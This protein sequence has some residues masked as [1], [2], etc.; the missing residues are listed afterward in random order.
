M[1]KITGIVLIAIFGAAGAFGQGSY[2]EQWKQVESL[3]RKG[4]PQSALS[5]VDAIYASARQA[6]DGPQFLKAVLYQIRLR[7]D[8][9]EDFIE[10]SLVQ[11]GRDISETTPPVSNILHSVRAELYW[12][13]YQGN[14]Y[15][16]M[17]RTR[18][19]TPDST[20][21]KT[22][23]LETLITQVASGY[24]T[25]L[26]DADILR[27]TL[28]EPFDPIIVKKEGSDRFRPT[29]YDFL[30][31][32]AADFFMTG[33]AGITRPAANF[34]ADKPDY[35]RNAAQFTLLG[36]PK[37][38]DDDF[39]L[40]ALLIL[41]DL[42]SFHLLDNDPAALVDADLKRLRFVRDI[43]TVNDRDELYLAALEELKAAYPGNPATADVAYETALEYYRRGQEYNPFLSDRYRWDLRKAKEICEATQAE[44]PGTDGSTNCAVLLRMITEPTLSVNFPDAVV[45]GRPALASLNFRN[46][47]QATFR[48]VK[49]DPK[50]VS[51][52][53]MQRQMD[54]LA[55][56]YAQMAPVKQWA[57][58][59]PDEGDFQ[60][61]TAEISILELDPGYYV[62][63]ASP[64]AII[65]PQ[66]APV[67]LA[68][69]WVTGIS[70][71]SSG[72][73][74]GVPAEILILDRQKGTPLK[75]VR[76]EAFTREYD[77]K[78]R[79]Y[80][81]NPQGSYV[82][83]AEGRVS[84]PALEREMKSFY[85][86]MSQGD[87]VY[88]T[89]NYFFVYPAPEPEKPRKTAHFFTD[90]SIYRPGQSV[91]F[92]AILLN[93]SD[94][95]T[96][97]VAD[98][99]FT[100]TLYDANHQKVTES[101][102]TTNEF[103]SVQGVFTLPQGGLTG[104]MSLE[105][106]WGSISF[107]VE[108]YKRPR[109]R[110]EIDSL[111]GNY[112]LGEI[113]NVT[114][115]ALNYTGV[116][117]DGATVSYR[118]VRGTRF[119]VWR[120][121]WTWFPA[122]P[123][124]EIANGTV[125]TEPDGS[126][127]F[128]FTA[129]PDRMVEEK[130]QP[131]F[132]Y[133]IYVDV[134]DITGE[135]RSAEG[136]V[137]VGYKALLMEVKV[138]VNLDIRGK[139]QF[140]LQ[141][142]NLNGRP[143]AAGGKLSVISLEQ[144]DRLIRSRQ[145]ERPDVFVM[146]QETFLKVFPNETYSDEN[147]PSTWKRGGAM[148]SMTFNTAVSKEF[149]LEGLSSWPAGRYLFLM[150][151]IDAYG[152]SVTTEKYVTLYDPESDRMPVRESFWTVPVKNNAE[153][154]ETAVLIAG[155]AEKGVRMLYEVES[156][157][158]VI[159]RRWIDL[160]DETI[161][162]EVPVKEEYRGNFFIHLLFV[163]ENRSYRHMETITVP[164]SD[165][166]L[167]ISLET[168][169]DKLLP[170]QD[171]EWRIRISGKG[172]DRVAAELLASMY[173]ASLDAFRG[174][175]WSFDLYPP[176]QAAR[177]WD[178]RNA[179]GRT[180]SSQVFNPQRDDLRTVIREYDRLNWFGFDYYGSSY[181]M[182]RGGVMM[183]S[184]DM[185]ESA[186]PADKD[187]TSGMISGITIAEEVYEP[188]EPKAPAP[189]DVP[190][191]RN[192]AE[193]AFF[194]PSL[195]T[196]ANGDI[197]LKFSVPESLTAWKFM[198]LAHSADLKTGYLEKEV[199]TRKELM[200]MTN[201]PR[202]FREGD[203]IAFSAKVVS[204]AEER[205][206]GEVTARFFNAYT[207]EPIDE[208]AGNEVIRQNL[209]VAAGESR[210]FLWTITVP[211]GVEAVV[212][213][214]KA[215]AGD[216]AD[217]EEIAVPVL[218]N[219]MLVT[220]SF[221]LPV[222]GEGVKEF[223]FS[224]LI[225]SGKSSTMKNFRLT[226]EFTSNPA[227]YAI[228]ALPYL[229]EEH[230]ESADN[231]F[232]RFYANAIAA[233]VANSNPKIRSV[234]ESWRNITPDA[235]L[236]NLEKNPELKSV[237]LTETPW[238]MEARNESERKKRIA[239]LFDLNR[240]ADEKR[241]AL[242]KLG[243][244]QA[245]NGGW[246]WFEGMPDSR[247]ITQLIVTGIGKLDHMGA[248]DLEREAALISMVSRAMV[249]LDERAREDY[250]KLKELHGDQI[251]GNHLSP[252][253]VQYLYAHSFFAGRIEVTAASREAFR[254]FEEQASLHWLGQG[255]YMQAMIAL[256]LHRLGS[257]D[258]PDQILVSLRETA[259][260]SD[261]MGMYW[262]DNAGYYWYE[263]PIERQAMMIG[264]FGEVAGDAAAVEEMKV[265]L[266]KQ[267]QTRDW[268]STSATADAIYALLLQGT[269]LLA[270]DRPANIT[271]GNEPVDPLSFDGTVAEAG[272]GYFQ[273]SWQGPDIRPQMGN[274]KVTRDSEGVAW[275][276]LYWQY[277]EQLDRITPAKTPLSIEKSLFLRKN[278]D[279]GPVLQPLGETILKPGDKVTVRIVIRTD[280]DMEY[281]HLKDMR[282]AA[283][284]P[285]NAISG[286]RYQ[287]GLGYYESIRDASVN[288][289]IDYL[290]KGTYV[291]EYE[292]NVTQKGEFS[293]GITSIQCLYAPEFAAHSQGV[294]V[295]VE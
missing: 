292:L 202:F 187:E 13:Y 221:P 242:E 182:R 110:V 58:K 152:D 199:I 214:V 248:I 31:H 273:V 97:I 184:L 274:V 124:T 1:R 26:T 200:V 141:V 209:S 29:L 98:E 228:Q 106:Q 165:K 109:F 118:V 71:I 281:V 22:W 245:P 295:V 101:L 42:I 96:V 47:K 76:T 113:V 208:L 9:Q 222:R 239:L 285:V 127:R 145:G 186:A 84:I 215:V 123:E 90:R 49:L 204:M 166:E 231:L 210:S 232:Q 174:H 265:W 196:D 229:S 125:K 63:L 24:T 83:D 260:K 147:D 207:M 189:A 219:R 156:D 225:N 267:K 142:T 198:A 18:M 128:S 237:L 72:G 197:I 52:Q 140:G 201:A 62:M 280:R 178:Y 288:F 151:A 12:R 37:P 89:P 238:V 137:S 138:P 48:L 168:F 115:S 287:G 149:T 50:E 77:Y 162:L 157:G 167:K 193:T 119:P 64:E 65:N 269:D 271:V 85:L 155:T 146:S 60:D 272:T 61:H 254:Y 212:C 294:R 172:G 81:N 181:P 203:R 261:E 160:S 159:S 111:E 4:Q 291:F 23:D 16:F 217:G 20:D 286:Y 133:R 126:F 290:R 116:A 70:Y 95:N 227:W 45:P 148:T 100:V 36:L 14:R 33:E 99:S 35:F 132:S 5:L 218:P 28:L 91:Y 87:D 170:G 122:L 27:Q 34:S 206:Q 66:Q 8:Y 234:I 120:E 275:G 246:S 74:D 249:Y 15:V 276:A 104:E 7:S 270:S 46:I 32:R 226:L 51:D 43:A 67:A 68:Y 10:T 163:K 241:Q 107:S 136:V 236:S 135:V 2:D 94:K 139:N 121:W 177:D 192:F 171:E 53:R 258:I 17:D 211:S 86:E 250:E 143:V 191:R 190:I 129:I 114:G 79:T 230:N 38:G 251:G 150:E 164:R 233:Y 153:P 56:K 103:G 264:A 244:M 108:E 235:F 6:N 216:K 19:T 263:A 259:L 44:F 69:F 130:F 175:G 279:S 131:V 247:Y 179:F 278:T 255:R 161:T 154:G 266:L 54:N 277:Y 240:M 40:R 243:R 293:N 55:E 253:H 73:R 92:K 213:Q 169:R 11:I 3:V 252:V 224:R 257:K 158:K 195:K 194:F 105:S 185:A 173:D 57:Q 176:R 93:R 112:R 205:L 134:T 39:Q 268:K 102:Y 59:L 82:S 21:M 30:A 78:T 183:K 220:E 144:P 256:A 117:V 284:E 75:G 282:A 223:R 188:E 262:R 41:Q 289:F 283:F 80:I 25:S 88:F 180:F